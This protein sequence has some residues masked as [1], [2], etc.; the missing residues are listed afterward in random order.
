LKPLIFLLVRSFVNG[1]KRAVS[2][3][4]RLIGLIFF[5]GYYALIFRPAWSGRS[6]RSP[7]GL[8]QLEFP[9]VAMIDAIIFGLFVA[10]TLLSVF[11]VFGYRGGFKAADVDVLFPTPVSP[12]VV[13]GFRLV[14]DYLFTLVIPLIFWIVVPRAG[15]LWTSM[16]REVPN[17]NS[18][19]LVGRAGMVSY[20]LLAS[21]WVSV[22]YAV[23]L[24]FNRPDEATERKR[25]WVGW[26]MFGFFVGVLAWIGF[27]IYQ[28]TSAGELIDLAG[29]PFLRV[30]FFLATGATLLTTAPL[31]GSWTEAVGGGAILIGTIVLGVVLAMR[32][33]DW[34]YEEAAMRADGQN[35]ARE[36]QKKGD[37]YGLLA[38]M[39]RQG[40]VRVRKRSWIHQV[41]WRGPA[42][43][44]WKEYLL[45]LRTTKSVVVVFLFMAV[46]L[47]VLVAL[48]PTRSRPMFSTAV[49]FFVVQ[50]T[51]VFV[52]I[53]SIAQSGFLE[54]LRRVDLQKPLPFRPST[55]VFFEVAAKSAL[56]SLT[57]WAGCV[58]FLIAA[59]TQ[60]QTAVAAAVILPAAT[61]MLSAVYALTF[62][63]FPDVDD[64]TQR[65]FRGLIQMLGLAI[66]S[67]PPIALFVGLAALGIPHPLAALPVA[68][69]NLLIAGAASVIAG[70]F[71]ASFNP[72]E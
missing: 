66:C 58:A 3:P 34:M 42:A 56:P 17:P 49:P 54:L 71:Y 59:P 30:V 21:A 51:L 45:Q 22:G 62:V 48:M 19:G 29:H 13:L 50:G 68:G 52:S 37:A 25:R 4:R 24:Y 31:H 32:Q 47:S 20:L 39:A 7:D 26:G 40:K 33:A 43:L 69:M 64:P 60:W 23:S 27:R 11:S 6:S 38:E 53:A 63:L 12:K 67:T 28:F 70:H 61:V 41:R 55:I 8:G 14:R 36:L 65:G 9:A 16:F 46:G 5:L 2:S 1:I 10:V 72:S 15:T 57:A 35:Q 18:A 44:L